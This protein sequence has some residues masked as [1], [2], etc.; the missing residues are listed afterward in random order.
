[1]KFVNGRCLNYPLNDDFRDFNRSVVKQIE[2]GLRLLD[3]SEQ[4]NSIY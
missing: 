3:L 2:K 1:M 4:V